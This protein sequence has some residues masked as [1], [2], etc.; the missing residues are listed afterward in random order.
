VSVSGLVLK[1]SQLLVI[2]QYSNPN[3]DPNSNPQCAVAGNSRIPQEED[4]DAVSNLSV[5]DEGERELESERDDSHLLLSDTNTT[6]NPN[7][8]KGASTSRGRGKGEQI[9][10]GG[11]RE[12]QR[13]KRR[14]KGPDGVFIPRSSPSESQG[15]ETTPSGVYGFG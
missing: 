15:I 7:T 5:D 11:E 13:K 14:K 3:S 10:P 9:T 8:G 4:R 6:A 12:G 2:P 1:L